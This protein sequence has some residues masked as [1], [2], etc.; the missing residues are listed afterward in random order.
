MNEWRGSQKILDMKSAE[1]YFLVQ[2]EEIQKKTRSYKDKNTGSLISNDTL[3]NTKTKTSKYR[4]Q[5]IRKVNFA[6][7]KPFVISCDDE[8]YKQIWEEWLTEDIRDTIERMGKQAINKGIGWAYPWINSEGNL[9]LVDLESQTIYPAWEDTAHK[10]LDALVRDYIVTEYKNGTPQ[11][12]YKVE[13]WDAKI[14]QKFIDYSQGEGTGSLVDDNFNGEKELEDRVSVIQTHMSTNKGI[15]TSW[16][17]VPFLFFKGN[18]D[19]LPALNECKT[20]IDSYDY[21]KSKG[22]DSTLDD[23]DAVLVVENISPEW[24]DL[25]QARKVVQESRIISIEPGGNAHFEK[26]NTDISGVREQLDIIKKDMINDTNDI[27]VTTIE[28]GGNPSGKAMRMFF[29]PLNIWANGYEKQFRLFMRNL[30]YFFDKWL[31]WKGGYG[32]FE[33]LQ[34]KKITFSLDRDLMIDET[35]IIDNLVKLNEEISKKR[36]LELN[37]Y[38]DDIEKEMKR[39]E[40]D[41]QKALEK[42]E[43]YQMQQDVDQTDKNNPQNVENNVDKSKEEKMSNGK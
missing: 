42:M 8:K 1:N 33:E 15:G 4:Q 10:K 3:A 2:N 22:I 43:M 16:D 28:F 29:E 13:F 26:V 30:K 19:E 36:R 41:E 34:K 7:N 12:L 39:Q 38:V 32:T 18:D 27:D 9:D 17:K 6:L 14:F 5:V 11:Q 23:I 20:D 40:E 21:L 31:S 37:P 35:D 25:V 24:H